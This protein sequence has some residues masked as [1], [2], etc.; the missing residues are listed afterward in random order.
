MKQIL[1]AMLPAVLALPLMLTSCESD[2]ESNPTLDLS[3]AGSFV[4]N[5]PA[6]ATNNTYDLVNAESLELTCSQPNYGGVPYVTDYRV[7]VSIDPAF[8]NGDDSAPYKELYTT[9]QTA[10]MAVDASEVNT[11]MVELFQ[12]ANPD[13]DYPA[14][15]RPLYVKVLA[16][17]YGMEERGVSQSNVI[18]LP[19]VLATYKAPAAELPTE[20]FIVGSS[21]QNAWS[22]WKAAAPVYGLSGQFYTVVYMPANAQFKWGLFNNDWRGYDRIKVYDDQAGAGIHEAASDGNIQIDNAG[23]YTLLFEAEVAGSSLN[24]TLHVYPA[25]AGTVGAVVNANDW[26]DRG[27]LTAPADNTGL[28]ESPAFTGDGELRAFVNIPGI[29]WWRTEFTLFSGNLYW[30][31]V[32]IPSNWA[33]N[34]GAAYSVGCSAGQKLYVDFDNNTGEVK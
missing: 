10:K 6:N 32:D 33:E 19:S 29:D 3:Q 8:A 31:T 5:V 34:V 15:A 7:L 14:E 2:T 22:S 12:E 4:L 26:N 24:F 9:Y 16:N 13:T 17:L 30:R 28:W 27:V 1:K 20:L 23:W 11:A 25:A 21:I 18:T